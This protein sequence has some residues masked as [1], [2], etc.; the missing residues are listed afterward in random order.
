MKLRVKLRSG[1]TRTIKNT[2][3]IEVIQAILPTLKREWS[4]ATQR[5]IT[6]PWQHVLF[7]ITYR[8]SG[9][10]LDVPDPNDNILA[11]IEDMKRER[12]QHKDP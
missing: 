11:I 1:K 4:D 5:R 3:P 12:R 9:L 10:T 8:K 2:T 7:K 6:K